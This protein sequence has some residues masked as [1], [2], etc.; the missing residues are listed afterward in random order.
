MSSTLDRLPPL[1]ALP[2]G[3]RLGLSALLLTLAGGYAASL[4]YVFDHHGKKDERPGLSLTDL[5]GAYHGVRAEAPLRR[6]V[7]GRH[8]DEF[9]KIASEREILRKWLA[10]ANL[11][12]AYDSLD[13]GDD[14]PAEILD[15]NCLSCH[16]RNATAGGGIGQR[17]PLD[18]WD[19]VSKVA[20]DQE[21][22][23]VPV[24]ILTVSTHAHAQTIPLVVLAA[25]GLFLF[26]RWPAR[27]RSAVF[28]LG[29]ASVLLDVAGWWLARPAAA[30]VWL[31]VLAGAALALSFA[32]AVAGT[33]LDLWLPRRGS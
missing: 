18:S 8:G 30:A 3:V 2:F 9:L 29:G 27:L 23:P 14:A 12:E 32:A 4:R 33:L 7:E 15:R 5:R 6:A 22:N 1:R 16:A 13:L 31:I 24:E 19:A 11:S 25:C 10:G 21:L 17:I 20:F 28:L 26:T